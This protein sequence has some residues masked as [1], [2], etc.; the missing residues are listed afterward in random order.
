MGQRRGKKY[1]RASRAG[2][3]ELRNPHKKKVDP[4]S[5]SF[6]ISFKIRISEDD[7]DLESSTYKKS[8]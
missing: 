7:Q 2:A 6:I 3:Q 1:A 5:S 4:F 8:K